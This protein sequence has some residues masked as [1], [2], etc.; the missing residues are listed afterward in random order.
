MP[1]ITVICIAAIIMA[2]LYKRTSHPKLYAFFNTSAGVIS[3]IASETIFSGTL[4]GITYYNAALSAI[5]G[6]PGT[7]AHRLIEMI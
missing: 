7:V 5:L 1:E 2:F 3:L 4:D 6:I